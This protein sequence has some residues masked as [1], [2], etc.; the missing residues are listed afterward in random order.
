M[1]FLSKNGKIGRK[2]AAFVT[3]LVI[4]IAATSLY[5][6]IQS[7]KVIKM[8]EELKK[9]DMEFKNLVIEAGIS[10]LTVDDQTNMWVGLGTGKDRFGNQMIADETLNQIKN[11]ENN[12]TTSVNKLSG[13]A[14]SAKERSDINTVQKESETFLAYIHNVININ[15][16]DHRKAQEIQYVDSSD[17][18]NKLTKD[19][20]ELDSYATDRVFSKSDT[21]ASAV[22]S[23]SDLIRVTGIIVFLIGLAILLYII[24]MIS[25]LG[26]VTEQ[27]IRMSGGDLTSDEI[28]VKNK[29]EIGDLANAFNQMLRNIRTVI[30]QV[31]ISAEQV[32][33]SSEQLTASAEQTGKAS[34]QISN[35]IQEVAA[36]AEKQ[37]AHALDASESV[38]KIS[39]GMSEAEASIQS[40]VDLTQA[41]NEKAASGAKMVLHT[42]DQMS[43]VQQKVGSTAQ[44]VNQLG[45]KSQAIS[46]IVELITEI[47]NQTNL[48]ALNAS[49]EAARAGEHGKGFAVVAEEVGKL[50]QQS[51][52]AAGDI[53]EIITQIQSEA[54]KAVQSMNEGTKSVN[55]GITRVD[56]TGEMFKEIVTMIEK[57]TDQSQDVFSIIKLANSSS[58]NL[59][60]IMDGVTQIA[61][62]S[63]GNTQMVAAAAEQQSASMQEISGA[64]E[65]LSRMAM[66]L[67]EAVSKF[68]V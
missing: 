38:S 20:Q 19:L 24:K 28:K 30:Q 22:Q 29:D 25:P 65:S 9:N 43:D 48:L 54:I 60:E 56:Q 42:V 55:E 5:I 62:Q 8:N 47:A 36:G 58:Q 7:N 31:L 40:V 63:S 26:K 2:I 1:L 39:K 59:V 23:E 53:R 34:E 57:V 10:F 37:A 46:Q 51:S 68:K 32:A 50:A 4:V 66:E 16:T 33:A 61:E 21:I 41:T 45:E 18:S 35:E 11:A 12:L 67:Q 27:A 52:Q 6:I 17:I 49:I 64:S 13:L 14:A 3:G 44:V 15:S